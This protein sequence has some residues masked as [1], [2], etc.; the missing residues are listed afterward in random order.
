[1]HPGAAAYLGDDQKTFFDR[2]GDAIFYGM[3]IIPAFGSAIAAVAGY[4]RA[5]NR[6]RRVRLLHRLI[7]A[8]KKARGAQSVTDLVALEADVDDVLAETIRQVEREQL[9]EMGMMSFSLAIHQAR[10][11]IAERRAV[12]TGH[13]EDHALLEHTLQ[14]MNVFADR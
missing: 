7:Q 1:M 2:Y 9:D 10:L 11:A 8:M 3:L 6:T 12:L 13:P 14:P 5:D 4:L